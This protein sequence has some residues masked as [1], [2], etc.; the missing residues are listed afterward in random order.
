MNSTDVDIHASKAAAY[1][2]IPFC[3]AVCP[4]CDFAVVAGADDRIER[5]ID[6]VVTEIRMSGPWQELDAV[7]FGGGTPSHVSPHFLGLS[8]RRPSGLSWH[9][10]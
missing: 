1:V 8:S 4:Y 2:H 5:Y 6:A 10:T 3:S 7:Y 9:R